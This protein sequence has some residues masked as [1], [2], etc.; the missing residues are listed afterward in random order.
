MSLHEYKT[1]QAIALLDPP[2]YALIM[3]AMRAADSINALRLQMAWP[4][5]WEEMQ[6]RYNAP[7]G[8]I[9][10]DNENPELVARAH[11]DAGGNVTIEGEDHDDDETTD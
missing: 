9:P 7:L 2:F 11:V 5:V 3:A 6:A 10:G 4:H 8:L 1:S